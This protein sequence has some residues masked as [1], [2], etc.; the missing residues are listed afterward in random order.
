[1]LP[2]TTLFRSYMS[3]PAANRL[4]G[5]GKAISGAYL[6]VDKKFRD[7][8]V[9]K[10]QHRPGVASIVSQERAIS[11][12]MDTI[13]QSMLAM[14]FI[15]SLFAGVIALGVVYNSVRIALSE[16]ERELASMRVLGFTRGEIDYIL[17]GEMA[18]LVLFAIPIGLGVGAIM[19]TMAAQSLQT[20]MYRFPV[21]LGGD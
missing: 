15:L 20:E 2:Y 4:V 19:S 21:V 10:L 18:V 12:F 6:M 7:Q 1:L 11:S 3:L 17:L 14:T 13:A 9:Q 5:E 16:R 8:L